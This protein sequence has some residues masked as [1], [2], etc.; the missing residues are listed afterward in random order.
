MKE[1]IK[2][3]Q[4]AHASH[5]YF[6][7]EGE[8]DLKKLVLNDW[9]AKVGIQIK[10][11]YP[12]I[13]IECW[14]PE[15]LEKKETSFY[16]SDIKFRFFPTTFSPIYALDFSIP[17]LKELRKEVEKSRV[18]NYKLI[19]HLH[20]VHNFHGLVIASLFKSQR[21]IVQHHG[22]SWPLKHIKQTKR[23]KFFFPFFIFGQIWENLVLKNIACFFALNKE[24]IGYL[25]KKAL[26]SKIKFQT[27][28]IS[29]EYFNK[30]NK[31]NARKKLGL[32]SNKKILLFIGRIADIKGV[33]TLLEAMNKMKNRDDIL[34]KIIGFGPQE[35]KFKE[36]VKKNKLKNVEFLGGV[37]GNKKLLYLS[38][39]DVFILPSSKEGAPVTI[40]E[41]LARNVPVITSDVGGIRLMIKD[42]REGIIIKNRDSDEIVK[43]VREIFRWKKKDVRKY[44]NRYKWKEI[45]KNTIEDY[46]K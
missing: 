14:A 31:K 44:A 22:G 3:I 41:S 17:M 29:N 43:A 4:L 24:E 2:V 15:K 1:K 39:A 16:E 38:S 13:E 25:K 45:I 9:Y 46:K 36:Y 40:M 35:P 7:G 19:I 18:G 10:K 12:E 6:L 20:E 21:I 27:M 11:I 23:Y 37:F 32:P 42:R 28:G 34:L 30:E 5:S 26:K 33:D 8:K